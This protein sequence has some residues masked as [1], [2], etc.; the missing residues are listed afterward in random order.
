MLRRMVILGVTALF[1][2]S[3]CGKKAALRTP[4]SDLPP[5]EETAPSEETAPTE[6]TETES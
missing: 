4:S 1:A 3:A 6:A 5:V 2:V